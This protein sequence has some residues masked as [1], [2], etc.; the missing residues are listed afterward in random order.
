MN[1]NPMVQD[2][3]LD[4]K[5]FVLRGVR[6]PTKWLSHKEIGERVTA[7]R[8]RLGVDAYAELARRVGLSPTSAG[9]IRKIE[10]GEW[11]EGREPNARLLMKI[12]ALAGEDVTYFQV[13][14]SD[15]RGRRDNLIIAAWLEARAAELRAIS[16]RSEVEAVAARVDE[17]RELEKEEARGRRRA[18][19]SPR[20]GPRP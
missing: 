20:G 1:D 19:S 8:E 17:G 18:K 9:D 12:A 15:D 3:I 14:A 6:V 2:E 13:P 16:E 5:D 4:V 10:K 7:I 11:P